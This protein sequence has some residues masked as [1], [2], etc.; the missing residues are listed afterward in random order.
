MPKTEIEESEGISKTFELPLSLWEEIAVAIA[1]LDTDFSKFARAA[2][3]EK[4]E[5]INA[6]KKGPRR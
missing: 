4:L 6:E 1:S 5:R 2:L 3:R